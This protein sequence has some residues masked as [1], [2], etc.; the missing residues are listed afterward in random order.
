MRIDEIN[1]LS[2]E[3][4]EMER[5]RAM[6]Q[7]QNVFVFPHRLASG[8]IRTVEV[9]STPIDFQDRHILFSIIHD[10][11][12][13]KLAEEKIDNL[14]AEL[15]MRV[16]LRTSQLE[17]SNKELEAFSY[18]VAHDLRAPLRHI[19]GYISLLNEKYRADLPEKAVHYLSVVVDASK[20]MDT[21]IE[22]LLQFS[23]TGRQ[24]LREDSV[25]MNSLIREVLERI[26][27]D[28]E[29]R[30]ITWHIQ[31]LPVVPGDYS[32]L[33][34]V[35]I[36]L[37]DNAVKFTRNTES[38]KISIEFAEE[39]DNIVFSIHDNGIG[40]DM[41]YAHKLFGVFQRLHSQADFEGTGIGLANVQ[42]IVH[43]HN[44]RVWAEAELGKGSIFYVSLPKREKKKS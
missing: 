8:E 15:E 12:E 38:A 30:K 33:K 13:R 19:N 11:T 18:S 4:I 31:D 35:W 6:R 41:C 10:I 20:R 29:N 36:N 28:T 9:H 34:Q 17:A 40:F 1:M 5:N 24:E 39:R 3:Q 27:P 14:N 22:E 2:S 25:D 16:K 23:R 7:E 21:L 37:L 43:R 32:L 42:R 44:G 26:G